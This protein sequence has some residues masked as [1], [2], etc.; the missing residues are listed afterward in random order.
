LVNGVQIIQYSF[1]IGSALQNL[2]SFR[3]QAGFEVSTG[4]II[5]VTIFDSGNAIPISGNVTV[6]LQPL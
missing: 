5:T 3:T 4:D 2:Q 6:L 1:G